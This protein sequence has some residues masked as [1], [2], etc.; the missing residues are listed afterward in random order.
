MSKE[1]LYHKNIGDMDKEELYEFCQLL[2]EEVW[3]FE[4]ETEKLKKV[5]DVLRETNAL[6]RSQK[7]RLESDLDTLIERN[8][9][10]IRENCQLTRI[11]NDSLL[12]IDEKRGEYDIP[13]ELEEI[14]R[15]EDKE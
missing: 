3:N 12:I 4:E 7:G 5:Q 10:L 8:D 2:L 9:E 11:I 15:G 13:S 6:L 1:E 14:L